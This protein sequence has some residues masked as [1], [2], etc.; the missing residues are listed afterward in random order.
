MSQS[1][2]Q[3]NVKGTLSTQ[4][5]NLTTGQKNKFILCEG[6]TNVIIH[7][8]VRDLWFLYC[9]IPPLCGIRLTSTLLLDFDL[10]R[11]GRRS[12]W[13]DS[14]HLSGRYQS[15]VDWPECGT[16]LHCRPWDGAKLLDWY[17]AKLYKVLRIFS[18][19]FM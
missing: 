11:Q 13:S 3:L 7:K 2:V 18:S 10:W 15:D 9:L 17:Q 8:M 5:L 12:L 14:R 16:N 6:N 1:P 19:L 4:C